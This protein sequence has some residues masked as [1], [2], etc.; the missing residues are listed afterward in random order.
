KEN[1]L[2]WDSLGEFLALAVSLNHLGEK[3]NNPK[4]NILGEALN[5]ATT[6]YLDNDKSPSR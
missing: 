6:K 2:R 4:A 1:H 3:Y 5:N